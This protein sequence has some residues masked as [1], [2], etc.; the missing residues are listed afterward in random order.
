MFIIDV[1]PEGFKDFE[2][3]VQ[4]EGIAVLREAASQLAT[5]T[6]AHIVEEV[7]DKLHSTRE[8]YLEALKLDQ[9]DENTWVVQLDHSANWI[10]DGMDRHEMVDQLLNGGSPAYIAKDGTKYKIIPFSLNKP[11]SQ[12]TAALRQLQAA[13]KAEFKKQNIPYGKVEREAD[14]QPKI[15]KLHKLDIMDKPVKT[16]EGVGQGHGPIGA[17]R[18]GMSGTPFLKAINVF[19]RQLQGPAG[20]VR[21]K[22]EVMTFRIVSSK[23]KGSGRWIHPGIEGKKFFEEA[24]RWAS[25]QWEKEIKPQVLA[26]LEGLR[27]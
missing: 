5:Q 7:Q 4:E 21:I 25:G 9:V 23:H 26:Q 22:R 17:V 14:G 13:V 8:K 16:A 15:G 18:Q 10:E 2:R 24:Y 6:Y 27:K 11:P 19:Q 1:K 20:Q 3:K 12:A